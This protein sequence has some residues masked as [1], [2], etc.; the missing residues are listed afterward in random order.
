MVRSDQPCF[1]RSAVSVA[2]CA[3]SVGERQIR[4]PSG[5]FPQDLVLCGKVQNL[6]T[7]QMACAAVRQC[8][9]PPLR[10]S[11]RRIRV[12]VKATRCC[13][14]AKCWDIRCLPH[15]YWSHKQGHWRDLKGSR[16]KPKSAAACSRDNDM[17]VHC[18]RQAGIQQHCHTCA[19]HFP[20]P[21]KTP[22]SF[23][24]STPVATSPSPMDTATK[25]FHLTISFSCSPEGHSVQ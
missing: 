13:S 15:M 16:A 8:V 18:T 19:F 22:E 5:D 12:Q 11:L 23:E 3:S 20:P 17:G 6:Q 2:E 14:R 21:L 25:C 10:Q 1:S 9:A 4:C 24:V 7:S